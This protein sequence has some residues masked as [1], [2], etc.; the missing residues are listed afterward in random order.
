LRLTAIAARRPA[1]ARRSLQRTTEDEADV[2]RITP[3]VAGSEYRIKLEGCLSG[4]WV[5]ELGACWIDAAIGRPGCRI[6]I[7]LADVCH[8]D[9]QGR[10]LMTLMY[11]AGVRFTARGFVMPEVVREI[12]ESVDRGR[13]N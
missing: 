11:R 12:S 4:P 9:R 2:L 3:Y 5:A 7:D 8:V 1:S 10:E 6:R 13:R